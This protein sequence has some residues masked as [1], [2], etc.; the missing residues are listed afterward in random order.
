MPASYIL[1][2]KNFGSVI[3][4]LRQIKI[5]GVLMAAIVFSLCMTVEAAP[6]WNTSVIQAMGIGVPPAW[7]I[8]PAQA[9]ALAR[10][11][12]LAD[13]RRNLLA[14]IKGTQVDAETTVENHMV[15]SDLIV[16]KI[17]GII[18][19]ARVVS[20]GPVEGGG[21]QVTL[22]MS[23]FGDNS[24]AGTVIERP[25]TIEPI[26]TPAPDYRPP[27]NYEPPT[28][29]DY[30]PTY[31][32]GGN[33]TGLVVDCR[34]IGTLN[35]VMSPVIKTDGGKKIY[36]HKNLDYDRVIRDGMAS[37]AQS[38]S[39]ASRAGSNPLVVRAVRLD[40]LNATPVLSRADADLVLYENSRS[41][42]LEN[43]AVVFLY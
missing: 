24:L 18:K 13:A 1:P 22:E 21:Y 41:N 43:L 4:M 27:T 16:T 28:I 35:P 36:G 15:K 19:G 11:A 37:Y 3:K 2:E 39:Q 12:A 33:Y 5:F 14:E 32:G 25:T 31:S 9:T 29:P 8:S 42:F 6:N 17:Q 20:E 7:A 40:D 30:H 10:T 34:D 23:M 26:P 38:M